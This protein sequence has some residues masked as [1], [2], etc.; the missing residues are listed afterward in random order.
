MSIFVATYFSYYFWWLWVLVNIWASITYFQFCAWNLVSISYDGLFD[1]S[2]PFIISSLVK[3][4]D[5]FPDSATQPCFC[6]THAHHAKE[7]SFW[8][9][10]S[11]QLETLVPLVWEVCFFGSLTLGGNPNLSS[12]SDSAGPRSYFQN[13]CLDLEQRN[14]V[15]L[16]AIFNVWPRML[17]LLL[18][19]GYLKR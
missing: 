1:D 6:D 19:H 18:L 9:H 3:K 10:L 15:R 8:Y 2:G 16:S 4:E 11:L 5:T 17:G 12:I 13:S 14:W 7:I